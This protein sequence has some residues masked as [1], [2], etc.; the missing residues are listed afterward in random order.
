MYKEDINTES[1]ASG[2]SG[3]WPVIVKKPSVVPAP[4]VTGL[5]FN[6]GSTT[7]TRLHFEWVTDN[8]SRTFTLE[9]ATDSSFQNIVSSAPTYGANQESIAG[10]NSGTTYYFR[11]KGNPINNETSKSV[12]WAVVSGTTKP[13]PNDPTPTPADCTCVPDNFFGA[14]ITSD[15]MVV[16]A[17]QVFAAFPKG[18]QVG[19]DNSSL[20]TDISSTIFFKHSNNDD[21]GVIA[22]S[23]GKPNNTKFTFKDG[24]K[25]YS[26]TVGAS[27]I[28]N[29]DYVA[30]WALQDT[31][32]ASCADASFSEEYT[33]CSDYDTKINVINGHGEFL[34]GV[35]VTAYPDGRMDGNMCFNAPGGYE[36][37][38][39][40]HTISFEGLTDPLTKIKLDISIDYNNVKFIYR[41]KSGECYEGY[42]NNTYNSTFTEVT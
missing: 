13:E 10:L 23:G 7:E 5:Q 33:C 14:D 36:F 40:S 34:N 19:Y 15:S 1:L 37:N 41:L 17:G 3:V 39:N 4:N 9:L 21:A 6:E 26:V 28:V 32:P 31:L 27:H 20:A 24:N 18:S 29:G 11:V 38:I 16:V 35:Q 30:T 2:A 12:D 42:L 25:C 8:G 22:L